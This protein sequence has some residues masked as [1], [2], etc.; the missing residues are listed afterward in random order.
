LTL[1]QTLK[2]MRREL[3]MT[4]LEVSKGLDVSSRYLSY[5]EKDERK[6]GRTTYLKLC[7]L[8]KC[9]PEELPE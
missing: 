8:Y 1:G 7:K 9:K 2:L 6:P 4:L 5:I 3:G